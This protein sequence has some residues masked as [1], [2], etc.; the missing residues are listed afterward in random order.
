MK[1]RKHNEQNKSKPITHRNHSIYFIKKKKKKKK[2]SN[3]N[4]NRRFQLLRSAFSLIT[5]TQSKSQ[6]K[7]QTVHVHNNL[8]TKENAPF[9]CEES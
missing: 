7:R 3:N 2:I 6:T 5:Q 4:N 1:I 8:N 9:G